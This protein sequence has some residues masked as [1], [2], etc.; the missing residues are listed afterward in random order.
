[1][2]ANRDRERL[3]E[4]AGIWVAD[5][6][7]RL[8]VSIESINMTIARGWLPEQIEGVTSAKELLGPVPIRC[9]AKG[10]AAWVVPAGRRP[11]SGPCP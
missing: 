11:L 6:A 3:V 4:D 1:M 8:G 9:P 7:E 2:F 5:Q 10:S